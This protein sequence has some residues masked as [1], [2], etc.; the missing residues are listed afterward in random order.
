[1]ETLNLLIGKLNIH[2]LIKIF[3]LLCMPSLLLM[4]LIFIPITLP[5]SILLCWNYKF[6][7]L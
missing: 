4:Y 1:M 7:V 6:Q 3:A 2:I 5:I